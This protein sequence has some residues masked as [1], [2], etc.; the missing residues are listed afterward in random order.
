MLLFS[1]KAFIKP[2]KP[3]FLGHNPRGLLSHQS[4][5]LERWGSSLESLGSHV[6]RNPRI[7]APSDSSAR[8]MKPTWAIKESGYHQEDRDS[9]NSPWTFI[10]EG[11][12]SSQD[13]PM[14][15]LASAGFICNLPTEETEWKCLTIYLTPSIHLHIHPFINLTH[16]NAY[17]EVSYVKCY[18]DCWLSW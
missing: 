7:L 5:Q 11:S 16:M 2:N 4:V 12:L 17:L 8:K 1:K 10:F 15:I 18:E 14:R 9:G 6:P 3:E 13:L